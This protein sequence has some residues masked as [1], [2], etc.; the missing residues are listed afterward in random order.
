MLSATQLLTML[1]LQDRMNSK[2][3]SNWIA[4]NNNWFRAIQ[5]EGVEAI[6][7]HG[8]KWWKMQ[9]C[10]LP[11]LRMELVD[12]WHFILSAA[13]QNKQGQLLLTHSEMLAD[14]N[15]KNNMVC[16]DSVKYALG[17]LTLLDKIDLMVGLATA[18]RYSLELFELILADC[19]MSWKEL[20]KQYIGK[21]VLNFFRQDHGYKLG[22]YQKMW[23]G[24]EDNEHLVELLDAIDLSSE[25]VQ[26][27]LYKL[28][29]E[30]YRVA[31]GA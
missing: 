14:L 1:E 19:G 11:Q 23:D 13:I 9:Q 21:N 12:I 8:W 26:E 18:R 29:D 30:R 16:F 2:V 20:F 5:V 22:T 28:L 24:R 27:V 15:H 4:Q 10:D 31:T 3:D 6:E 25:Q 7:H 17:Q